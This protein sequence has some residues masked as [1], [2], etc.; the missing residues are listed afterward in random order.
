M[1]AHGLPVEGQWKVENL[2][3]EEES[4]STSGAVK[5]AKVCGEQ[6]GDGEVVGGERA[7]GELLGL[8]GGAG[9][10]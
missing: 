5:C 6:T 4:G 8:K 3:E 7:W 10:E 9:L 2:S 1:K